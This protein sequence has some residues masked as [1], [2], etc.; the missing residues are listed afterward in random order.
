[1]QCVKVADSP[2]QSSVRQNYELR[3]RPDGPTDPELCDLFFTTKHQWR[4]MYVEYGFLKLKVVMHKVFPYIQ[5]AILIN[6]RIVKASG[7]PHDQTLW[8]A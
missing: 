2:L 4:P 3:Y 7:L 6:C 5:R 1:M 8:L